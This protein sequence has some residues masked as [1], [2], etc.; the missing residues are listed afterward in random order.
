MD[1]GGSMDAMLGWIRG[2]RACRRLVWGFSFKPP[3]CAAHW[4]LH[5]TEGKK[6]IAAKER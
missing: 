6:G 3:R 5:A 4:V 1:S 2:M